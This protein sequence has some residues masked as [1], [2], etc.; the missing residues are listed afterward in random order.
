MSC[1]QAWKKCGTREPGCREAQ[2]S[3]G[4]F[5]FFFYIKVIPWRESLTFSRENKI[6]VAGKLFIFSSTAKRKILKEA[7]LILFTYSTI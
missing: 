3:G 5:L 4:K 6:L 1:R 2:G 7:K